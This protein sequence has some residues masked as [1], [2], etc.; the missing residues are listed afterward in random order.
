MDFL[1]VELVFLRL[2]LVIQIKGDIG[3]SWEDKTMNFWNHV[4]GEMGQ[5]LG[6]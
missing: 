4:L 6:S 5:G 2:F 1:P 3:V